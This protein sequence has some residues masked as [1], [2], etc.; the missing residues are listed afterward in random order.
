MSDVSTMSHC[1]CG[2]TDSSST[3]PRPRSSGAP[4][5]DG[6]IRFLRFRYVLVI[7]SSH[8]PLLFVTWDLYLDCDAAMKS[9]VTKTVANCFA[10]LRQ[11]HSVQRSVTAGVK[12]T[13]VSEV[14]FHTM[15][16]R[17]STTSDKTHEA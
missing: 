2:A 9:N 13:E 1:G 6:N 4:Q 16:T 12:R 14:R 15:A 11:I 8:P 3:Q 5:V 17:L 7:T 10:A